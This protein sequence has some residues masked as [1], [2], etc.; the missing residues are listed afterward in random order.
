MKLQGLWDERVGSIVPLFAVVAVVVASAV[1]A[2]FASGV[3]LVEVYAT[4][5]GPDGVPV[6]GLP[7]AAFRVTEDGAP[8]EI[9]AFAAGEFPLALAIGI[10]RS[11][12]M[13][14]RRLALVKAGAS[15]LVDALA[16]DDEVMVI[17]I[18]SEREILAPLARDKAA[19]RAAIDR[20][21]LWGTTPLHDA[22]VDA[23]DAIQPSK[24]RRALVLLSDGDDRGSETPAAEVVQ[25]ARRKNVLVY[26][27]AVDRPRPPLFVELATVSGG[28]SASG[29][30]VAEL[31]KAAI[32]I[33]RE[34]RHQYLL[35]FVP[36]RAAGA[37]GWRAIEVH[38]AREGALVRARDGYYAR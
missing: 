23:I 6:E 32:G 13:S 10:D 17:A 25:Y 26:P 38:V 36:S 11:F 19:A 5:T 8:Q 1:S 29:K 18:G 37:P 15:A 12:S 34:L 21:D 7:A 31:Q 14:G 16:P 33:A 4:V 2:Q 27:I 28:R 9:A 3:N 30:N 20:I 35:G 22:V 24:G